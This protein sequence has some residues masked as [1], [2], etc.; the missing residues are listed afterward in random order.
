MRTKRLYLL[1][2]ESF[3][4]KKLHEVDSFGNPIN[5]REAV[6]GDR[7]G[8]C[9]AAGRLK[10][11][12]IILIDELSGDCFYDRY[13]IDHTDFSNREGVH[14]RLIPY[15]FGMYAM[16]ATPLDGMTDR[17][18]HLLRAGEQVEVMTRLP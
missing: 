4:M 7:V 18:Y 10:P 8:H 16:K 1:T 14:M 6:T 3:V 11:G 12:D 13:M 15:R 5:P 9:W 17:D 2:K